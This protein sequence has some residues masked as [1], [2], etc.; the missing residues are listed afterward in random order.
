MK[1][2]KL[3]IFLPIIFALSGCAGNVITDF[4]STAPID[5]KDFKE[6]CADRDGNKRFEKRIDATTSSVEGRFEAAKILV[7]PATLPFAGAEGLYVGARNFYDSIFNS[8]Q[9]QAADKRC[10]GIE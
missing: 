5:S 9:S 1:K 6:F 3:F 4:R 7:G 2:I 8:E 10:E